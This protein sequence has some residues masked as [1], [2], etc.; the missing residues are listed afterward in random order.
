MTKAALFL[1]KG[2]SRFSG[3]VEFVAQRNQPA[4]L[5]PSIIEV[6]P[7]C[8]TAGWEVWLSTRLD[9]SIESSETIDS[10]MISK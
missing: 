2:A 8:T 9:T 3:L 1:G 6:S 5:F 10:T 4:H 7:S